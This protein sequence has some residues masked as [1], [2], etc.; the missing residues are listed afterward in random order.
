MSQGV[1]IVTL[2][3]KPQLATLA[4]DCLHEM[5]ESPGSLFVIHAS[6]ARP[7][8]H[9]ALDRLQAEIPVSYSN[10]QCDYIELHDNGQPL[11]DITSPEQVRAAFRTLYAVVRAIKLDDQKVH[12][13]I[14]GGRRTLTVAGMATAQMLFD[15]EDRLWH[16]ASH[17]ALE[18]SGHL[19]V[20]PGEWCHLIPI[21]VIPWGRLSPVFAVLKAVEDPFV[22][23]Q[24]LSELRLRE[25]WDRARIFMLTQLSP[26]EKSVVELLVRDGLSQNEIADVLSLSPR[27]VEQHL[28]SAYQKAEAHWDL[29]TDVRQ[30][31]L[32]RLLSIFFTNEIR[33]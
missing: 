3:S 33:I 1:L 25:Q 30:P 13:L 31:Q 7:E 23:A 5:R 19:H 8:T 2:G 10:L 32:V 9:R 29:E 20:R 14:A 22:A 27:T 12:L 16:L 6:K 26:A 18:E 11:S 4:L 28:R 15:D 17:P 24:R 21:P